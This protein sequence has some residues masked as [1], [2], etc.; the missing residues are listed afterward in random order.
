MKS[1]L[2][3]KDVMNLVVFLEDLGCFNSRLYR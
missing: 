3:E 1:L 2:V